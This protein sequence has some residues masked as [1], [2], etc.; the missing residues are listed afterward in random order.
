MKHFISRQMRSD[1][2]M[3]EQYTAGLLT[4][5]HIARRQSNVH[6]GRIYRRL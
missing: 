5:M 4:S 2:M 3:I 1:R 6:Y